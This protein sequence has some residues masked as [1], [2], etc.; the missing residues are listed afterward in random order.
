MDTETKL[1]WQ[2]ISIGLLLVIGWFTICFITFPL[3]ASVNTK[4]AATT[5]N[6]TTYEIDNKLYNCERVN[7]E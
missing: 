3:M 6:E 5:I 4:L 2:G 7:D 1:M